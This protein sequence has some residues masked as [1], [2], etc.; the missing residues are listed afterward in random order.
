MLI[1]LKEKKKQAKIEIRT[2]VKIETSKT[3]V[4]SSAETVT[5]RAVMLLIAKTLKL[6]N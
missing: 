3:L 6:K 5:K 1:L 2:K 4:I